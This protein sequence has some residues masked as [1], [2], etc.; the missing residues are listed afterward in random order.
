MHFATL[1]RPAEFKRVRGGA[2][3]ATDL[4]IIECRLRPAPALPEPV[5]AA[6][7]APARPA[8]EPRFGFTITRKVGKAVVRNRIRRRLREALR[9]L[10]EGHARGDSDY[11]VVASRGLHDYPFAGLQEALRSAFE[12]LAQQPAGRSKR[13]GKSRQGSGRGRS[14]PA[15]DAP[16]MRSTCVTPAEARPGA[17]TATDTPADRTHG[18][19]DPRSSRRGGAPD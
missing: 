17:A 18:V 4:F 3:I 7:A 1:K 6:L 14:R 9:L 11:V 12:R 2:R 15:S 8:P 5:T 19:A 10:E 13:A 16:T